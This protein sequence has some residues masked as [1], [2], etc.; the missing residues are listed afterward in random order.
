MNR[1]KF[2]G[3]GTAE[4]GEL[5]FEKLMNFVAINDKILTNSHGL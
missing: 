3:E 2:L 5:G 1:C 4:K